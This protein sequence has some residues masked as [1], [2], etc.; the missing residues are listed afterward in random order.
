MAKKTLGYAELQWTCPNCN[1]I[2]PGTQQDCGSC[3][4]PQPDDV[5]FEQVK[6]AELSQDE[7]LKKRAETGA[8]IH[9]PYCGT[10]NPGDAE[11]CVACGGD[12]SAGERRK[13]GEILGAYETGPVEMIPAFPTLCFTGKTNLWRS[14][15]TWTTCSGPPTSPPPIRAPRI[16]PELSSTRSLQDLPKRRR[17]P[18]SPPFC[19]READATASNSSRAGPLS[20]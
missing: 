19:R 4:A 1:G 6:G 11:I 16:L 13:S 7:E 9:C 3:G 18:G 20:I 2:N 5:K 12:I 14:N 8:D 17:P 10:R 15:G